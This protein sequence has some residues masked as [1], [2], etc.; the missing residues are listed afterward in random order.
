LGEPYVLLLVGAARALAPASDRVIELP[1]EKDPGRLAA[2][3]A[4]CDAFV[5]ANDS[6]PFGLIVLEAM[7]CGLPVVGVAAGGVGE[8]VDAEVGELA[9]RSAGPEFAEAVEALF[10][11]DLASLS[12]AARR[13]ACEQHGW[14]AVFQRLSLVYADVAGEPAFARPAPAYA[15]AS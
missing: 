8:S 5:H 13:R 10:A 3:L 11:R 4:S 15:L 12:R 9:V 1:Y 7:A 2:L 14:D 6:E